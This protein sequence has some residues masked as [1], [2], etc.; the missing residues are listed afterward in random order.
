MQ[1]DIVRIDIREARWQRLSRT[2]IWK[3]FYQDNAPQHLQVFLFMS[4]E[5]RNIGDRDSTLISPDQRDGI[6]CCN[7]SLLQDGEVETGELAL[8]EA[9]EDIIALEF[10]TELV[11]W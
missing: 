6:T 11:A 3:G 4:V 2:P 8:K 10:D 5:S 9:F 1:R 7:L